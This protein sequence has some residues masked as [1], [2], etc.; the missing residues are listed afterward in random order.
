MDLMQN[1]MGYENGEIK[2]R[3][4]MQTGCSCYTYSRSEEMCVGGAA[5]KSGEEQRD[6]F[7]DD[8]NFLP[9]ISDEI[10]GKVFKISMSS[11]LPGDKL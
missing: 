6:R 1:T 9:L 2:D 3:N 4:I 11:M 10:S 8:I 5:G 7:R